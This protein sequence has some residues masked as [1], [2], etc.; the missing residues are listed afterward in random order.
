MSSTFFALLR[1]DEQD[2]SSLPPKLFGPRSDSQDTWVIS[3]KAVK[4]RIWDWS[5]LDFPFGQGGCDNAITIEMLRQK[6]FVVNPCMSLITHHVHMTGYRTYDPTDIV[7]KPALM[8]VN[9][10]GLHD[11]NPEINITAPI[12]KNYEIPASYLNIKGTLTQSQRTTLFTMLSKDRDVPLTNTSELHSEFKVPVYEFKN[13]FQLSTG[14]L[15][16]YSSII[17]GTSQACSN[18]WSTEE[19]SIASA[20]V[21]IDVGLVAPCPDAIAEN[22]VR[23]IL[24]YMGKIFALRK[25]NPKGE[26]LGVKDN[27]IVDALK[28]FSWEQD[29]IPVVVRTP[30][31]QTW[32]KKAYAWL[33]QDGPK[34]FVIPVEITALREAL[35]EWSQTPTK[36]HIVLYVDGAWINDKTIE[37]FEKALAPVYQ[38]V[39]IYPNTQ[40]SIAIPMLVGA[41]GMITYSGK[42]SINRW[43]TIWALPVNTFVWEIQPEIEPSLDLYHLSSVCSLNH[44]LHIVPRSSATANDISK[45]VTSITSELLQKPKLVSASIP[46]ILVPHT[47]TKGFFAHAGDSFREMV[48]LWGEK[49]YVDVKY[50]EGLT[51][52]WLGSVG[53]TLLYDRPTLEWLDKAPAAEKKWKKAYFGN[54]VPPANGSVWS[55]WPRQPIFPWPRRRTRMV[56]AP[57]DVFAGSIASNDQ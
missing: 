49:G 56:R 47:N 10:T 14:L 54:P 33:P 55:F 43:G 26:W 27:A 50:V 25:L 18:A 16:T 7:T 6:F 28:L 32:C 57:K 20:S 41:A 34:S 44:Y 31:F 35:Q 1:W 22:P 40:L 42:D 46:Q 52:I 38:I 36:K 2:D 29:N 9:P 45:M 19:V 30:A 23:Y 37:M 39:C 48:S 12:V 11:L 53:D 51:H 4:S 5:T 3:A 24:E 8:Y 17:V 21:C 15:R 13:I